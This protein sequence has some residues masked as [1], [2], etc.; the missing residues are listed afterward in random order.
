MLEVVIFRQLDHWFHLRLWKVLNKQIYTNNPSLSLVLEKVP[1]VI[2]QMDLQ[3]QGFSVIEI[4]IYPAYKEAFN[5]HN[6]E[7]NQDNN[8]KKRVSPDVNLNSL[9][10]ESVLLVG[11]KTA[12]L[13]INL[14]AIS[15]SSR[16]HL[17]PDLMLHQIPNQSNSSQKSIIW[18]SLPGNSKQQFDNNRFNN[19][20]TLLM[21]S[22]SKKFGLT[23]NSN[24]RKLCLKKSRV[25]KPQISSRSKETGAVRPHNLENLHSWQNNKFY[26]S[27]FLQNKRNL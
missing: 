14:V 19:S 18:K 13:R 5:F 12:L 4:W 24:Q 9:V 1:C 16:I 20:V 6:S 21:E 7:F 17:T 15:L 11:S 10:L 27:K 25:C 8:N 23:S 22:M 26:S 3:A 2:Q